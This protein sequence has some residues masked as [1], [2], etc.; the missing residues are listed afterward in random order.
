MLHYIL[1]DNHLKSFS[2]IVI[3]LVYS[4]TWEIHPDFYY[5]Q[6]CQYN[7]YYKIK[8]TESYTLSTINDSHKA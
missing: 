2:P 4:T 1:S 3:A 7:F 8:Q 5:Y 6:M